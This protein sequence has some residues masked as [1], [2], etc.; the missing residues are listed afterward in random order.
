VRP[1]DDSW[2][3]LFYYRPAT[4]CGSIVEKEP[5]YLWA[6]GMNA[7]LE[8]LPNAVFPSRNGQV[9]AFAGYSL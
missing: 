9:E 8:L 2:G 6:L 5:H 7:R 3:R 4:A 1:N